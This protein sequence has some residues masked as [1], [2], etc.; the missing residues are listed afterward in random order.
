MAVKNLAETETVSP[1][2]DGPTGE[3]PLEARVYAKE[4]ELQ[5]LRTRSRRR[6]FVA[7]LR[8]FIPL[9]LLLL[10]CYILNGELVGGCDILT[11]MFE[12]G[13]VAGLF[14]N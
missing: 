4:G 14:K 7:P 10:C 6:S 11:S 1:E 5:F 13:E 12:K 2:N 8:N 3:L 9:V